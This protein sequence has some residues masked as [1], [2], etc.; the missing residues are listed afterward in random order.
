[1]APWPGVGECTLYPAPGQGA[2]LLGVGSTEGLGVIQINRTG[3][4]AAT[5]RQAHSLRPAFVP[6]ER[7]QAPWI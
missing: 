6:P 5:L 2:T 7:N 3:I 1:V 4:L